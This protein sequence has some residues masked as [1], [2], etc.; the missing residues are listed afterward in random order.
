MSTKKIGPLHCDCQ[1]CLQYKNVKKSI[2]LYIVW[3]DFEG[4]SELI[5]IGY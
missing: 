1:L 4:H 2:Y 3:T 5:I